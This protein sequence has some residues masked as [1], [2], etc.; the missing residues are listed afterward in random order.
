MDRFNTYKE[1]LY[2]L[3]GWGNVHNKSFSQQLDLRDI[4]WLRKHWR[5]HLFSVP[6]I[7]VT[8]AERTVTVSPVTS[9]MMRRHV[10]VTHCHT[11][12]VRNHRVLVMIEAVMMRREASRVCVKLGQQLRG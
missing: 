8:K 11:E 5:R 10:E 9:M 1:V 12:L 7:T 4:L 3:G 6:G 2:S